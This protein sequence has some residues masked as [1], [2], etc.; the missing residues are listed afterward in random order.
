MCVLNI[1]CICPMDEL[2]IFDKIDLWDSIVRDSLKVLK[3]LYASLI[4]SSIKEKNKLS[5]TGNIY[6]KFIRK[7][8]QKSG[9]S[10][11]I[12]LNYY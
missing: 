11:N 12:F 5:S 1:L 9:N 10:K 7:I 8:E 6:F 4:F 3:S 2:I